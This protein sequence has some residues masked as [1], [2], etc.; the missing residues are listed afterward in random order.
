M[1]QVLWRGAGLESVDVLVAKDQDPE[2][3]KNPLS[4]SFGGANIKFPL[5]MGKGDKMA[6]TLHG[7]H[8]FPNTASLRSAHAREVRS[9]GEAA[10]RVRSA[11]RG[12]W[13]A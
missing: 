4:V 10:A 1:D 8:L 6:S 12:A 13:M 9:P 3:V 5:K 11:G 7:S 2:L